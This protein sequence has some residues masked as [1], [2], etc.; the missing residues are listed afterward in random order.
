[1]P[2]QQRQT[3]NDLLWFLVAIRQTRVHTRLCPTP[4]TRDGLRQLQLQLI[5]KILIDGFTASRVTS[6]FCKKYA[7]VHKF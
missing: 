1:L 4:E 6:C 3:T 5:P 7:S 2:V